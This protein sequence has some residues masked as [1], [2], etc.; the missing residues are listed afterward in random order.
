MLV[1]M[2]AA[3]QDLEG[4]ELKELVPSGQKNVLG[5]DI[6]TP[7]V[8]LTLA[9]VAIRALVANYDDERNLPGEEKVK[10]WQLAMF[11]RSGRDE[12]DLATEEVALIKKLI[13]KAYGPLIVGQTWGMLEGS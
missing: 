3:L 5:N 10:R 11:I 6:M 8:T 7:G 1:K 2:N 4:H 9:T 12:V 13:A